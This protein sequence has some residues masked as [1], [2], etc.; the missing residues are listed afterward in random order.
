MYIP[1]LTQAKKPTWKIFRR[2]GGGGGG[3]R[4]GSGGGRSSGS[5]GGSTPK[6][7]LN[8]AGS[9]RSPIPIIS[10][11]KPIQ[12]IPFGSGGGSKYIIPA[13]QPFSGREVGGGTR[14]QV[15]GT[16]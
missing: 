6:G 2:K 14:S 10:G 11:G 3:G 12:A 9:N 1:F 13:Q 8:I 15:Y 16:S 4:G 7:S 5:K